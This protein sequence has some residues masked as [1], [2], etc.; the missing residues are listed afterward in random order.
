MHVLVSDVCYTYVIVMCL[1]SYK[2]KLK[3]LWKTHPFFFA[4]FHSQ[5]HNII[6]FKLLSKYKDSL[7]SLTDISSTKEK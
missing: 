2:L 4:K 1:A 3:G 7:P 5:P 6:S